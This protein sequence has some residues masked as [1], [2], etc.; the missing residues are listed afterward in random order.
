[1]KNDKAA[2]DQTGVGELRSSI[3][4]WDT[5]T[6]EERR[7]LACFESEKSGE[8]QG[9]GSRELPTPD[10]V[11]K[12]QITL[13]RKA[14]SDKQYRFWSLYGEVQR[15]D[16]LEAAWKR[17]AAKGG[18]PGVDEQTIEEISQS[19][20]H[21]AE[22]LRALRKELQ[23]KSYRPQA[24][25]RV[26]IPKA[27]GGQR[28]LGIPT[29]RDRVVQMAVYLVL[30]PIFEA[31]FHPLSYG[32][33]PKR[34]AHQAVEAIREALRIGKTEVVDVDLAKYFDTIPHRQLLQ[35]VARRVSDGMILKLIKQWLR[36]PIVEEDGQGGK[37]MKENKVGTPQG[38]VISPLLANIYL[39]PLDHAVNEGCREKPRLIRYA[40]DLVIICRK[41][42]GADFQRRLA[43]W[44]KAKGLQLNEKKTRLVDSRKESFDFLG[45]NFRWQRSRKGTPYVHTE[46]NSRSRELFR[47]RMRV[48]LNRTTTWRS[49]HEMIME[50]N[51]SAQG[52]GNYFAYGNSGDMMN[53]LNY[54][55]AHRLRQWLWRKHG[56]PSGRYKRWSDEALHTQYRLYKFPTYYARGSG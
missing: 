2:R 12:L 50:V 26:M 19:P 11:R 3:D 1:M 13:Y 27:S 56:N 52:W 16:A 40:D 41:G 53:K 15:V 34:N 54:F 35:Q 14:Q 7:E 10:K 44:L 45:F 46:V 39:N 24:V 42:E 8:G 33:R 31:D 21:T 29:V 17:V 55:V 20:E 6:Q 9:D 48:L 47:E 18:A 23:D 38:G 5:I 30:M 25:R 51:R 49:S 36:A 4:L 32:F 22:W 43:Y 28:P 37:R